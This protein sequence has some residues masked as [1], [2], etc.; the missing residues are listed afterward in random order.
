MALHKKN[1]D[2]RNLL[3]YLLTPKNL[4]DEKN[5]AEQ[6]DGSSPLRDKLQVSVSTIEMFYI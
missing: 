3:H 1:Q 2:F 6:A 5:N 4:Q